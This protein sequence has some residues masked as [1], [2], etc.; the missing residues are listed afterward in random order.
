MSDRQEFYAA[1][2]EEAVDKASKALNVAPERIRFEVLD[3]GSSGFLGIG[4]RDARIVVENVSARADAPSTR[5]DGAQL[6]YAAEERP[7]RSGDE[8]RVPTTFVP[9]A[10]PEMLDFL[11][12]DSAARAS[13]KETLERLQSVAA[14]I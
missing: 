13:I 1:T 2:V 14:L 10:R 9:R 5:V 11:R 6:E 12:Q 3:Q 4:T 7:M 8:A